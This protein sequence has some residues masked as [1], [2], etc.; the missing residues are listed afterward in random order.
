M[1]RF[2]AT[3]KFTAAGSAPAIKTRFVSASASSTRACGESP[4]SAAATAHISGYERNAE[5]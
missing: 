5:S 4:R 1:K 2:T 3:A